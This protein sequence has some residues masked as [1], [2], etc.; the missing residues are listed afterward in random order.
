MTCILAHRR[1]DG[2]GQNNPISSE[3]L[4]GGGPPNLRGG[5]ST[6]GRPDT[7]RASRHYLGMHEGQTQTERLATHADSRLKLPNALGRPRLK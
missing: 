4:C 2:T 3:G 5:A 7:E 6:G 1:R